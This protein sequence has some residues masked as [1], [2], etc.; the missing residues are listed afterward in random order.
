MEIE[1]D[2]SGKIENTSKNTIIAFS[3]NIFESIFI[4]AKDK[5]EIQKVFRRAGKSRIFVYKLFVIL[6][7][8]LVKKHLKKIEHIIIDDE[9]PG[10]DYLIKNFLF[11]EI[12]KINPSFSADNITIKRIGKKSK[13]HYIA[14]GVAIGKRLPDK[15]VNVKE[16]LKFIVK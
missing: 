9:Y 5:R 6:I 4:D 7:F 13:A 15:R 11:Q 16:I 10:K 14:Y 12:N 8:L 3:N 2:Q 1:V